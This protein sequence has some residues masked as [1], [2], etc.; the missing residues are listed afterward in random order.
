MYIHPAMIRPTGAKHTVTK[1]F[2]FST[3]IILDVVSAVTLS[4]WIIKFFQQFDFCGDSFS[5]TFSVTF[6]ECC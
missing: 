4:A 5:V 6:C 3:S 1:L 2:T